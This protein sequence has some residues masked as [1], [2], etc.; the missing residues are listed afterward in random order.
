MEIKEIGYF[1]NDDGCQIQFFSDDYFIDA[2]LILI[3]MSSLINDLKGAFEISNSDV[4]TSE[5]TESISA[6]L[7]HKKGQMYEFFEHGGSVAIIGDCYPELFLKEKIGYSYSNF[8]I[9]FLELLFAKGMSMK[10]SSDRGDNL[11]IDPRASELENNF[12]AKFHFT[13]GKVNPSPI[14]IATTLKSRRMVAILADI[15]KGRLMVLPEIAF[16]DKSLDAAKKRKIFLSMIKHTFSAFGDDLEDVV[17]SAPD[18]AS[19]IPLIKQVSIGSQVSSIEEKIRLE[20]LKL[21]QAKAEFLKYDI[22]RSISYTKGKHL[23]LGIRKCF[24]HLK[25]DFIVPEGNN[26]DLVIKRGEELFALEIK[27]VNSS[28]A[29]SHTRQLEDWVNRCAEE[30]KAEDVK[31]VLIINCFHDIPIATRKEREFP[32]NVV[33]YSEPRGHCLMTTLTL[34]TLIEYYDQ[35]KITADDILDKMLS[36]NGILSP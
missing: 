2:N 16:K 25:I 7:E 26:T 6:W 1:Y 36:T 32:Q 30:F 9:D 12:S 21:D 24:E 34:L 17:C 19:E 20:Q 31:G 5:K 22:M 4:V 10:M 33:E 8:N 28:A 13:F 23:E 15:G 14:Q 11:V 27:G 3:K 18:W 35:R 29:K